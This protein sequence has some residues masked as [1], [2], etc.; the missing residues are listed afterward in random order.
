MVPQMVELNDH[1]FLEFI[2]NGGDRQGTRLIGEEI[3]II[4]TLKVKL[5]IYK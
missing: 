3:S 2:I 4:S 5:Q 1:L